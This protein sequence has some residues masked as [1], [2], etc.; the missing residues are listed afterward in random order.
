SAYSLNDVEIGLTGTASSTIEN[1]YI[2]IIA[3]IGN[4][5]T[6]SMH[7][8][9]ISQG[10]RF[11]KYVRQYE[12]NGFFEEDL[13]FSTTET[14]TQLSLTMSNSL[15]GSNVVLI[16]E[17]INYIVNVS[18]I[19]ES[20]EVLFT[21]NIGV[22][23][24]A[25]SSSFSIK[26][27]DVIHNPT[28]FVNSKTGYYI[29]NAYINL[30]LDVNRLNAL[31]GQSS[32][33]TN[34]QLNLGGEMLSA[35]MFKLYIMDKADS[36]DT[37]NLF[38]VQSPR[39]FT[40]TVVYNI[41]DETSAYFS[42]QAT[43]SC[44]H[45]QYEESLTPTFKDYLTEKAYLVEFD[46]ISFN[47]TAYLSVYDGALE[48][49]FFSSWQLPNGVILS[50][51]KEMSIL[52]DSNI[53]IVLNFQRI[54]FNIKYVAVDVNGI[55]SSMG[56][57]DFLVNGVSSSTCY[58]GNLI[59]ISVVEYAG[60][61]FESI[62]YKK[63]EYIF[64]TGIEISTD[65]QNSYYIESF[66]PL[67]FL[68]STRD[69]QISNPEARN[70]TVYIQFS[71]KLYTISTTPTNITIG[72]QN[73]SGVAVENWIDNNTLSVKYLDN[74][75]G[76]YIYKTETDGVVKYK[77]N[78]NIEIRFNS[79][80]NGIRFVRLELGVDSYIINSTGDIS[81]AGQQISFT[82]DDE[83]GNNY[84][85]LRFC[86][87]TYLLDSVGANDNFNVNVCYELKRYTVSLTSNII[88]SRLKYNLNLSYTY[89][90]DG[91]SL[92]DQ[93]VTIRN[94][95]YGANV[96]WTISYEAS[97]PFKDIYT[98]SYFLT[99]DNKFKEIKYSMNSQTPN[100]MQF[101]MNEVLGED[102]TTVWKLIEDNESAVTIFA[103]YSPKITLNANNFVFDATTDTYIKT[104]TYN[105]KKQ[106]LTTSYD[107]SVSN[108]DVIY[109]IELGAIT[110][111]YNGSS[112]N[113]PVNANY[114]DIKIILNG[115]NFDQKVGLRINKQTLTLEYGGAIISKIYDGTNELTNDNL[116]LLRSQFNLKGLQ[117]NEEGIVDVVDIG[118][119][120]L[121]VYF[122][123]EA[124]GENIDITLTGLEIDSH[125]NYEFS[126]V[127]T[128]SPLTG[129]GTITKKELNLISSGFVFENI[130]KKGNEPV[131]KYKVAESLLFR[132]NLPT[133]LN[134]EVYVDL[135]KVDMILN[136]YTIGEHRMV[137]VVLSESLSGAD[138]SN[139][140]IANV[141][142]YIDIHP[143][144]ITAYILNVGSVSIIDK[145]EKCI[146]PISISETES[147]KV[148]FIDTNHEK[149]PPLFSAI[150]KTIQNDERLI[151][152][153]EFDL[154]TT[155]GNKIGINMLSGCYLNITLDDYLTTKIY[156]MGE[157]IKDVDFDLKLNS[158]SILIDENLS[159]TLTL[160]SEKSYFAIWK[161]ILIVVIILLIL[162]AIV[163]GF[164]IFKK[165]LAE[166]RKQNEPH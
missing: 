104:T 156:S 13:V 56:R 152:F 153:L 29:S 119:S 160:L 121:S 139:Y 46:D 164:I 85:I 24:E 7:K 26:I 39:A 40:I 71:E 98:F 145:E 43:V 102:G 30:N 20:A 59:N 79:S 158:V 12:N 151:G 42:A 126:N 47:Q 65:E 120:N 14:N 162:L 93:K 95:Y 61:K 69:E 144:E 41:E 8:S 111:L 133:S 110:I 159:N 25:V 154:T 97:N 130:V 105:A 70:F 103:F 140:T 2:N 128:I 138:S 35:T 36:N 124:V 75:T 74:A 32:L 17:E 83:K 33:Q 127:E 122:M 131:L 113:Y 63:G 96:V 109:P 136:N 118:I 117:T 23:A 101:S 116:A 21:N 141:Y 66:R 48:G 62:Y 90:I 78:E 1:G 166:K 18:Y 51:E 161:I 76:T 107:P 53:T 155:K 143:Y 73:L 149:Y 31:I 125:V 45:D 100:T 34:A 115:V 37:V 147:L 57:A 55:E 165:K 112:S 68:F 38:I 10:Y 87:N 84:Y 150:E 52:V 44:L 157:N 72:G 4:V 82:V 3:E 146:I 108:P 49:L 99:G 54:M 16:F 60:Y 5:V 27:S 6:I 92:T 142:Y 58:Y 86:L 148:E 9:K 94:L 88:E 80:F 11:L 15:A 137:E 81:L 135:E 22:E 77:T 28:L 19:G 64:T 50:T 89:G 129:K 114:Y 67:L 134:Q 132:E 91:I 106:P 163:I 123:Q